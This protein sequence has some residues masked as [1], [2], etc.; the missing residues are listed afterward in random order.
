MRMSIS[1]APAEHRRVRLPLRGPED[2]ADDYGG[3]DIAD[4]GTPSRE[5]DAQLLPTDGGK[6]ID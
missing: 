1:A 4:G 5:P 6:W 3:G 2:G